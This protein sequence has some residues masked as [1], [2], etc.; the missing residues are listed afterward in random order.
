MKDIVVDGVRWV[1][2]RSGPN[3]GLIEQGG[4]VVVQIHWIV[5]IMVV[6][7]NVISYG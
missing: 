7:L 1:P 5:N 4:S 3:Q 2:V 6:T